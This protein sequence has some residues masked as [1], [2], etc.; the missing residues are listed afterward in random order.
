LILASLSLRSVSLIKATN[1][2]SNGHIN[3]TLLKFKIVC[4]QRRYHPPRRWCCSLERLLSHFSVDL[5]VHFYLRHAF[6]S[7]TAKNGNAH[8][9]TNQNVYSKRTFFPRESN[10]LPFSQRKR[11][12]A[13]HNSIIGS[14]KK[15]INRRRR[16]PQPRMSHVKHAWKGTSHHTHTKHAAK[17]LRKTRFPMA[18]AAKKW[19][20]TNKESKSVRKGIAVWFLICLFLRF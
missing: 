13:I 19:R 2:G 20:N 18:G 4:V 10:F 7:G 6:P 9:N 14:G 17:S 5:S 12:F 8:S 11:P 3:N 16:W 15:G 1:R